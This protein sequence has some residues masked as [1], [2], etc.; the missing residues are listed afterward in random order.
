VAAGAIAA[1]TTLHVLAG[2]TEPGAYGLAGVNEHLR[3]LRAIGDCGVRG[4]RF[5]G[6]TTFL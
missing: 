5:E 3:L 2:F 4:M 1:C 6:V